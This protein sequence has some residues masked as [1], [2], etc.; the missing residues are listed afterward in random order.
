MNYIF[1]STLLILLSVV[2]CSPGMKENKGKV[3]LSTERQLLKN[4]FFC[5][6]MYHFDSMYD[7]KLND[8]SASEYLQ[9]SSY[10]PN[11]FGLLNK[12]VD[13]YPH[14]NFVSLDNHSLIVERCLDFYNSQ[15]LDSAVKSFDY[16]I[17][18]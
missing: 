3:N 8:G 13:A 9:Q 15:Y 2:T 11:I 6:C 12:I 5:M 17:I 7:D 16:A 4:S 14:K 18:K 1:K 10:D